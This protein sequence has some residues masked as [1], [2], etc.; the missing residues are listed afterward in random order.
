MRVSQAWEAS[1]TAQL[2]KSRGAFFTPEPITRFVSAWAIRHAHDRVMEPSAGDAA[3]MVAAT[4]RL[5][6]LAGTKSARPVVHGVEIHEPSARVGEER[7]RGAGGKPAIT[8]GDFFD[9]TPTADFDVVVGNPPYIRYQDFTGDSRTRA[10]EAALRAGVVLSG[11]ASSWA[12]FT[13]QSA[14]FL[15]EG[16]RLGLVLPAEL[17][18]VNYAAPVREFLFSNFAHV[19][20]VLFEKQIFPDAEADVVL[21][22]AEGYGQGPT[23]RAA[24]RQAYDAAALSDLNEDALVWTPERADSKWTGSLVGLRASATLESAVSSGAF[25]GLKSWGRTSLGIVT[26]NNRYFALSPQKVRELGLS[27][28][29]TLPLSPPGSSHLRGLAL[30]SS[31]LKRMG[32]EGKATRLFSP[33]ES[34]SASARAYIAAG[35]RAGIHEG[36]KCRVRKVWFQPPLAAPA[37]LL[38]TYMNADTARLTTNEAA[39]LHLNSVHGVYLHADVRDLGRELLPVASLNSVTLLDAEL[40]GR[41]YGGGVL[42]LEPREADRWLLPSPAAVRQNASALQQIKPAVKSRLAAGDLRGAV[43]RVDQV[44]FADEATWAGDDLS[45]VVAARQ[46]LADRRTNRGTSGK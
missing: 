9:V 24:F 2:R 32:A 10:R 1:D 37:D 20:L 8:V 4:R 45:A 7:V 6:D 33:G 16:G 39:A 26:G 38:L 31:A 34:P 36:Y 41:S 43:A 28:S 17:L 13:V 18:S 21:L 25:L 35:E 5:R 23:D 19:E 46:M 44:L 40:V 22:L 11:L 12:A 27:R 42:K 29:E 15:R 3:F 30:T 14:Q